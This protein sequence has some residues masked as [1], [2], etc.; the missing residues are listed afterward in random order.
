MSAFMQ[1]K[2]H[3]DLLVTAGLVLPRRVLQDYRLRWFPPPKP[4]DTEFLAGFAEGQPW[5]DLGWY[6][7][8]RCEL[9]HDTAGR[10]GAMLWDQNMRSVNF[11]YAEAE[12]EKPYLFAEIEWVGAPGRGIDPL[13]VLKAISGYEYQACETPDWRWT[14]AF[15]YCESLRDVAIDALPGYRDAAGW[16]IYDKDVQYQRGRRIA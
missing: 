7:A 10:V 12:L 5:G 3:I 6:E 11:R 8:N 15:A 13:V 14:E 2:A 9:T 16:A 1:S 4:D